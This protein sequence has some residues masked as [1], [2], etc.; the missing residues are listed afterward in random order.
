MSERRRAEIQE[1]RAR[2]AQLKQAREDRENQARA[3]A[4]A[5]SLAAASGLPPDPPSSTEPTPLARP[6]KG[7]ATSSSRADEIDSLLRT[8]GVA[9]DR[10]SA[11]LAP[12]SASATALGSSTASRAASSAAG[13]ADGDDDEPGG[14][15]AVES[16]VAPL[17]AAAVEHVDAD[18][19][20][21]APSATDPYPKVVYDKGIQTSSELLPHASTTSTEASTST[22]TA[23]TAVT[24]E[25][26]DTLRARIVAEL[27]AERA[28]L[29]AAI[30][31]ERALAAR[32]LE[33]ERA[34]GLAPRQLAS[35]LSSPAFAEF[36]DSSTKVVQRALSD[37][38]DYLRDYSVGG[39]GA[40]GAGG[41]DDGE[42]DEGGRRSRCRLVGRWKDE[43]WGRGRS[44]TGLDWSHKFP[45]LFVASYNKNPMAVNEPDGIAA[46]WNLHLL[47]RPEFV[48]HAQ[49]DIL[50]VSFS[51]FHPN[52]VVGGTYSGQI[53]LWD[54]RSR[55]SFP[56]LKTPLSSS[57]GH[58]HPVYSLEL[59]GT[60]NAH[61]LVSAS[62]D[63]TVCAWALD[64]LARPN[65]TLELV[66]P[67]HNKTDEVSVTAL[68]LPRN[69]DATTTLFAGTE[70]GTVYPAHRYDRAGAKAGIVPGE[71]Y[72]GHAG[73]VTGIDFHP[74]EGTVDLSDLFLTSGVDWTVKLWRVGGSHGAAAAASSS[75]SSSASGGFAPLLSFEEADDYV[76][77]VR[78]HPRH[79]AM[80]GSVDGAGRFDVWN[81]N[82]DTEV[83]PALCL[84]LLPRLNKLAWD[85]SREGRRAAV[86]SADGSVYVY[87]LAQDVVTPREGEWEQMR[88]TCTAALR[89]QQ[90]GAF[91]GGA[92]SFSG[93]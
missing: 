36:V 76:Y 42:G 68:G 4:A 32:A 21:P 87:E 82:V 49:S 57:G 92:G 56:V 41:E 74:V 10:T 62:T 93:R 2:L 52:L 12:D 75:S 73:P 61:S 64:M 39:G 69:A 58:T 1:K 40:P 14:R 78:W 24:S 19:A 17:S 85:R 13:E 16:P 51:P 72:R 5:A 77:D 60:P 86:G 70:E 91:D 50:S 67:Q 29:D 22:G 46:V 66:H 3:A 7:S 31:S 25:T 79:P 90:Q 27:E 63:G 9:R 83:R 38:Y 34:A 37:S 23:T 54:T 15:A 43:T 18:Q 48:F 28:A 26:A 80:F 44:V 33:L 88:K 53:L 8:V 89:A 35:V 11:L 59:V 71:A 81:L 47:E 55:H 6:T 84:F 30:A 45:E 65:E 20:W